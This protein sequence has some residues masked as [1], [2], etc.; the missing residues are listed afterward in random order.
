MTEVPN[1]LVSTEWLAAHLNAPDIRIVDASWYLPGSGRDPRAE[2]K[3]G[4]IPGAVFFD[5]DEICDTANPL[6]HMLPSQEKFASRVRK[7]GLGDGVK[8]IVYD[9]AG[10]FSAA[11]VWWM[12]RAMGHEDVAVLDGGFPKWKTE[13]RLIDDLPPQPRERHFTARLNRFILRDVG[14]MAQNL[15]TGAEQ[16]IDARGPGRFRGQE[17][18]PR[19]GVRPGHIPGAIN[20]P[21]TSLLGADGTM[22]P[23]TELREKVRAAGID[24]QK[25]AVNSCGSGITAA[26]VFLAL[27]RLGHKSLALYDGSWAE[28]GARNDLPVET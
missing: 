17:P 8:I 23:D 6:P 7:L 10:L 4:H 18:E 5:I 1:T 21:Y 11:R 25:P 2:Y 13:Q 15:R 16:V 22:L 26:I 14:Q 9:G 19:P 28:W 12:F 3:E 20:L 24:M 27:H